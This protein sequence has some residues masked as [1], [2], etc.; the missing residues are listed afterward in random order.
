MPADARGTAC[1]ALHPAR[2]TRQQGPAP[3]Y[4]LATRYLAFLERPRG[5]EGAALVGQMHELHAGHFHPV[6]GRNVTT[7]DSGDLRLIV[8]TRSICK[9]PRD[10]VPRFTS[11]LVQLPR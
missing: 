2:R 10:I 8:M 4:P 1:P 3:T 7:T 11:I 9:I 5:Q 6:P